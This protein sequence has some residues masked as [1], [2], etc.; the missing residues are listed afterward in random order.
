MPFLAFN[1]STSAVT[2]ESCSS[3]ARRRSDNWLMV[4]SR[5]PGVVVGEATIGLA[6]DFATAFSRSR[7]KFLLF[8]EAGDLWRAGRR[9][10]LSESE[11]KWQ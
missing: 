11:W 1:V 10:A 3:T 2:K 9:G 5:D 7:L 8:S 6:L 4:V